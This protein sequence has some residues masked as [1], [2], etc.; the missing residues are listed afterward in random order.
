MLKRVTRWA[1]LLLVMLLA[2]TPAMAQQ[3]DED[4]Y[5]DPDGRFTVPIPTNWTAEQAEGYGI[6]RDPDE[7]I[8]VYA[9]AVEAEDVPA[10][11]DA[12]WAIIDPE[13][14]LEPIQTQD[15]PS[16]QGIEATVVVTYNTDLQVRV[17]QAFGQLYDG[18]VYLLIFDAQTTAA[19]QRASQIQIIAGGL[20]IA[21]LTQTGLNAEDVRPIDDAMI[22][23]L[24]AYIAEVMERFHTPGLSVSIVANG[25]IVYSNGFGVTEAGGDQ[26]VDAA[27]MMMIGSTTKSMTTM[28]MATL[29][30]DGLMTWDTPVVDIMPTF[31]VSDPEITQR[32]TVRNMVCACTGVPRRD[33]E[34]LFNTFS[35]QEVIDS[36][37][38]YEFFT[39]FG[40]AFQYSNQMVATG[41]YVATLAA[42]GSYNNLFN[43]YLTAIQGRVFD[44]I[45]MSSTTFSFE[46]VIAGGDYALPHGVNVAG[47]YVPM[48]VDTERVLLPMAPAGAVWSN[49][50]D[51]A[52]Y[53]IT[54]LNEGVSPDG[55]RVVS[56]ENLAVTWEPQVAI[57]AD[58]SYGL[59]WMIGEY[60]GLRLIEHN[61]NTLGFSSDLA[62]LPDV[63]V[64]ISVLSNQQGA[65]INSAVRYRLFELLFG[66]DAE[67]D[68][69][70][71][72]LLESSGNGGVE[73]VSADEDAA[74]D[75]S[76]RYHNDDLGEVFV[77][78]VDGKLMLNAGEFETELRLADGSNQEGSFVTYDPPLAGL[79][80]QFHEE[81]GTMVM[82]IGFGVTEYTFDKVSS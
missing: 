43:D 81:D 41:G 16:A 27:T 76:G 69:D 36:L 71:T 34:W 44:P 59:G 11:I 49:V 24:E 2:I 78:Y 66:Q 51:M 74:A 13:F 25:E 22:A 73:Y 39:D 75:Y 60:N 42:G 72:A 30:D 15:V 46:D 8:I 17:V 56:A 62:F 26:P 68:A 77:G 19:Q 14:D 48:S 58:T 63:G 47:E 18:V 35:P 23:E 45:G 4:T 3:S 67:F 1:I 6:L 33:F 21:A 38:S 64:G 12:A 9:L 32:M 52:R 55:E 29:V 80:V 40:E 20:S 28:M 53:L 7:E 37:A 79:P 5:Q 70:L 82:V 57:T 50:E 10:G 31:A 65:I 61:G 54:E